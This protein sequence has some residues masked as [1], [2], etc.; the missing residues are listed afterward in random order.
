MRAPPLGERCTS[1]GLSCSSERPASTL[2]V[3]SAPQGAAP[4]PPLLAAPTQ[5]SQGGPKDAAE[6]KVASAQSGSVPLLHDASANSAHRVTGVV[7]G[8]TNPPTSRSLTQQPTG[9]GQQGT[10]APSR[11]GLSSPAA[12]PKR[13][14]N[15]PP[16]QGAA[17]GTTSIGASV[18]PLLDSSPIANTVLDVASTPVSA[19]D[20]GAAASSPGTDL[21]LADPA[22]TPGEPPSEGP[23]VRT[24]RTIF[25]GRDPPLLLRTLNKKAQLEVALR[26]P[27]GTDKAAGILATLTGY[28]MTMTVLRE[29]GIGILVYQEARRHASTKVAARAAALTARWR[30]LSSS[31][32][33]RISKIDAAEVKSLT[34]AAPDLLLDW[35]AFLRVHMVEPELTRNRFQ[36]FVIKNGYGTPLSMQHVANALEPSYWRPPLTADVTSTLLHL[37]IAVTVEQERMARRESIPRP[38]TSRWTFTEVALMFRDWKDAAVPKYIQERLNMPASL[39]DLPARRISYLSQMS[40]LE[41]DA[42]IPLLSV[43]SIKPG[44]SRDSY[45]SGILSFARF[46][47]SRGRDDIIPPEDPED[48]RRWTL[49]FLSKSTGLSYIAHVA[50]ACQVAGVGTD[51]WPENVRDLL[52]AAKHRE[53]E[54]DPEVMALPVFRRETVEKIVSWATEHWL[55]MAYIAIMS[56]AFALRVRDECLPARRECL[57]LNPVADPPEVTWTFFKG[58]KHVPGV[59]SKTRQCVCRD[60]TPDNPDGVRVPL[61]PYHAAAELLH[62]AKP[63]AFLFPGDGPHH[64][65]YSYLNKQLKALGFKWGAKNAKRWAS[66]GF[67]RGCATETALHCRYLE[68]IFECGDWSPES[69]SY[70]LYIA[71]AFGEL[72]ARAMAQSMMMEEDE[73]EE[74]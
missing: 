45:A 71:T 36:E 34:F 59:S 68:D 37:S 18:S 9:H 31:A 54:G 49:A 2:T 57:T 26:D 3:G 27:A 20:L 17:A 52:K 33:G 43:G 42:L 72:E 60:P 56:F 13:N 48:L 70:L 4:T 65:S 32:N 64:A 6:S 35:Q 61:C 53:V 10:V 15:P 39:P 67:R 41:L 69:R 58:R 12:L 19:P 23:T 62:F 25:L 40:D 47:H 66:H 73:L 8:T 74:E 28:P 14:P 24:P 1:Q 44:D 38:P 7:P 11:S 55:V 22:T 29:S 16:V 46:L 63:G 51:W 21:H 5:S 30:A 50:K